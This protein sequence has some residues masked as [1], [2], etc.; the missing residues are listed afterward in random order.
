MN[1][2]SVSEYMKKAMAQSRQFHAMEPI[3]ERGSLVPIEPDKPWANEKIPYAIGVDLSKLRFKVPSNL[4]DKNQEIVIAK[5]DGSD[6]PVMHKEAMRVL[7]HNCGF[8][9]D[10]IEKLPIHLRAEVV[11]E[12][13]RQHRP[14]DFFL[15]G[16][17]EIISD[18]SAGWREICSHA[19]IAQKAFN[20]I[21][22][23]SQDC[24]IKDY[25]VTPVGMKVKIITERRQPITKKVGDA[26]A[27]GISVHH[28]YGSLL[29]TSLFTERLS[30]LNGAK[31]IDESFSWQSEKVGGCQSQLEFVV[32]SVN[33]TLEQYNNFVQRARI[34][35]EVMVE[36][37]PKEALLVR[38][39]ALGIPEKFL[40]VVLEAFE[41]EEGNTEWDML[42]ALTRFATH[43]QHSD[44]TENH[45]DKF[46]TG[47]GQWVTE[48]DMVNARMPRV[49]ALAAGA[50]ILE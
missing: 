29:K 12:M 19:E 34:M 46:I 15:S 30:C 20:A 39:R 44:L 4:S 21:K 7:G 25:S 49:M 41:R 6:G 17:P 45:R 10:F 16:T 43:A 3:G 38:S 40:P 11:N 32:M 47:A 48:F 23:I 50:Q 22:T 1:N 35:S 9:V 36:G 14:Q 2:M 8:K 37:D 26:L 27:Y 24:T 18:I 28:R 33:H 31:T 5:P 42:N 13:L